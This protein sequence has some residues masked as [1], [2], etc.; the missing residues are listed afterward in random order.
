MTTTQ[1]FKSN[2]LVAQ[3]EKLPNC[4]LRFR[5]QVEPEKVKE[6]KSKAAKSVNKEV[7]VPGFRPGKAPEGLI[8]SKYGKFIDQEF[9]QKGSEE[10]VN[11]VINLSKYYPLKRSEGVVLEK[12]ESN[13][14]GAEVVF[15]FETFPEVPDV[16][17]EGL[18]LDIPKLEEVKPADIER[19]LKEI[20]LYHAKWEEIHDRP[21]QEND[22]VVIDIDVI[23]D[24]PFKAY[25]S[26]RF[27]VI[28]TGMPEWARKL[29]LGHKVGES[30]EGMSEKDENSGE[31][32]VPRKCRITITHIQTAELPELNDE[33]AKKAG[34]QTVEELRVNIG[35]QIEREK[36]RGQEAFLRDQVRQF[37]IE[38]YPFDLPATDLKNLEADCKQLIERDKKNFKTAD[39]LKSYKERLYEN[40]KG[41]VRLAYLIPHLANQ[42]RVPTPEDKEANSRMIEAITQHYMQTQEK[43]PEDQFPYIFNKIRRDLLQEHT[44]DKM[45]EINQGGKVK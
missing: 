13:D 6:L 16:K 7:S 14:A 22:F 1:E 28:P 11:E 5:V 8:E 27:H 40:A 4:T 15:Q 17:V 25:E 12:F 36:K 35:K 23:E 26:S 31:D 32:F 30:V 38:N 24:S 34:V 20:Q 19:T 33:L 45:I 18:K 2:H 3:M 43:I 41:V 39:E 42:L 37:L 10:I 9:R 21:V 44:I 29:V